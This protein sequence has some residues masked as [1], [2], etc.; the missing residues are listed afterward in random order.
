[1]GEPLGAGEGGV[2]P[3]CRACH[4]DLQTFFGEVIVQF[5]ICNISVIHLAPLNRAS[6]EYS[7]IEKLL[8]NSIHG[9]WCDLLPAQ[10]AIL[11][12]LG[13]PFRNALFAI[14][15]VTI[16]TLCR[17]IDKQL[18]DAAFEVLRDVSGFVSCTLENSLDQ[19][20]IQLESVKIIDLLLGE[21]RS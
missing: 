2:A 16:V 4:R 1:V 8:Y 10:W 7:F 15:V 19:N 14:Y 11:G 17:L 18:A 13:Q 6:F 5:V 12:S 3:A 21:L 9:L 20:W